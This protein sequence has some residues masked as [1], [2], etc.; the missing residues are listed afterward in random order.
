MRSYP[1]QPPARNPNL[2]DL[3]RL[4]RSSCMPQLLPASPSILRP[5]PAFSTSAPSLTPC[6]SAGF[7]L[8]DTTCRHSP[9]YVRSFQNLPLSPVL[10]FSIRCDGK[11]PALISRAQRRTGLQM[12]S[13]PIRIRPAM[14]SRPVLLHWWMT[15]HFK[16]PPA[17]TPRHRL[18]DV[19][20]QWI[21]TRGRELKPTLEILATA[22]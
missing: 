18:S 6:H 19:A 9:H 20:A 8:A 3:R 21:G 14:A 1:K 15:L 5:S 11:L 17:I 7:W 12:Q 10:A 16:K 4:A 22:M 2:C 13:A